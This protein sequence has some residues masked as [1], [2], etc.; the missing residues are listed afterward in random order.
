VKSSDVVKAEGKRES[1]R[2][3]ADDKAPELQEDVRSDKSIASR[4]NG[5]NIVTIRIEQ[6]K[7]F[8]VQN[9]NMKRSEGWFLVKKNAQE[10]SVERQDLEVI[11]DWNTSAT[12]VYRWLHL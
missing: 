2:V 7:D 3:Q 4:R 8:V 9:N 5:P 6:L 11:N 1:T 12:Q 10:G